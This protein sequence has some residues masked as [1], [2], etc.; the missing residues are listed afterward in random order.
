MGKKKNKR[1][2]D[3]DNETFEHENHGGGDVGGGH[4]HDYPIPYPQMVEREVLATMDDE[5]LHNFGRSLADSIHRVSRMNLN[6]YPWEVELCYVQ[7]EMQMRS[8]RRQAHFEWLN[9]GG[10]R[11][12]VESS[13]P[14][15]A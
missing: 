7:Q 13:A 14:E 3:M 11:A 6:P 1:M 15:S 8:I 4:H 10:A 5:D 9:K 12:A 2:N